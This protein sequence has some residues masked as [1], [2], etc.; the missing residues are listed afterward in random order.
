MSG[1]YNILDF[2]MPSKT[3]KKKPS[4]SVSY[5]QLAK[6]LGV[7]ASFR[8]TLRED[9]SSA[10]ILFEAQEHNISWLRTKVTRFVRLIED[11]ANRNGLTLTTNREETGDAISLILDVISDESLSK[12]EEA[13]KLDY[14][15]QDLQSFIE[16]EL[17]KR[18]KRHELP[19]PKLSSSHEKN[20]KTPRLTKAFGSRVDPDL[21]SEVDQRIEELGITKRE[22]FEQAFQDWLRKDYDS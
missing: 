17:S 15:C 20:L 10:V 7:K 16:D 22:A 8:W 11:M 4:L 3:R 2:A 12:L 13:G 1:G 9:R 6:A 18:R 5:S 14:Y 21:A 19:F